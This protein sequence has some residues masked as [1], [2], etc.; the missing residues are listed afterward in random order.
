MPVMGT[1]PWA[2]T[3]SFFYVPLDAF[4]QKRGKRGD[5]RGEDGR[6]QSERLD[7]CVAP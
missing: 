4:P 5:G 7:A 2:L 1:L 3:K 6:R